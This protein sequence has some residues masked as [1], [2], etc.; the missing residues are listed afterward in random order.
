MDGM[1]SQ[2]E[3]NALF[4]SMD[5]DDNNDSEEQLALTDVDKDAVGEIQILAWVQL[6]LHYQH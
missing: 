1:L 4:G 5:G 3:I 2:E 6:Q